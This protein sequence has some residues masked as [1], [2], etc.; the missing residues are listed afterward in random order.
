MTSLP[1]EIASQVQ[2]GRRATVRVQKW[3]SWPRIYAPCYLPKWGNNIF[4]KKPAP[5]FFWKLYSELPLETTKMPSSRGT[6]KQIGTARWWNIIQC[7]KEVSYEAMKRHGGI[8]DPYCQA[9]DA[10]LRRLCILFDS[11][12]WH[13]RRGKIMETAKSV[14]A[15]G[16]RGRGGWIE[17]T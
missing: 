3:W 5:R 8:L 16:W 6:D 15:R 14:G 4:V 17:R 13:S 1:L 11:H 2:T 12:I 9:E 7:W 10:Y